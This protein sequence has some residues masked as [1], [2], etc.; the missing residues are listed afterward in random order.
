[1][2]TFGRATDYLFTFGNPQNP[3]AKSWNFALKFWV[4]HPKGSIFNSKPRQP[5]NIPNL[6]GPIHP[7]YKLS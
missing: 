2:Y 4:H 3:R 6:F 5:T 1:M 7:S